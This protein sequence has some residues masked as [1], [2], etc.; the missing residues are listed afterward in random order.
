MLARKA[1]VTLRPTVG[2]LVFFH[3]GGFSLVTG[4][5][6]LKRFLNDELYQ[7]NSFPIGRPSPDRR[8][9]IFTCTAA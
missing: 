9:I 6:T 5:V 2:R 1:M 7:S 8:T 3:E 4:T